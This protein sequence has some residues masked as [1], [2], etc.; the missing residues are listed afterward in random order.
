MKVNPKT[1]LLKASKVF[2]NLFVSFSALIIIIFLLEIALQKLQTPENSVVDKDW[3]KKNVSLNS[4]G[5]RDFE[6][7]RERPKNT[8][9]I[10]MLGDSMTFG[11][12]IDKISDTYP[13]QLE[14]LLNK[15]SKQKFEVINT[16]YPG[17]NTD[18]QLYDLYIKGFNFQ[19]DMVFIGYY[20][21]DIPR[22]SYLRCDPTSREIIKGKDPCGQNCFISIY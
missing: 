10:L 4:L 6:Y 5:Y 14:V 12:G 17:Y 16:A 21:N 1:F 11:S 19:P 3:F 15:D 9:R 18:S 20:H 22:L 8:F 7:S 13:K 2:I